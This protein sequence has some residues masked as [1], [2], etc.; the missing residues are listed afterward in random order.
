MGIKTSEFLKNNQGSII[1]KYKKRYL[2]VQKHIEGYTPQMHK[3]PKWLMDELAQL[4]GKMHIALSTYRIRRY[5]FKSNW[6]SKGIIDQKINKFEE[7]IVK[8]YE[9]ADNFTGQII[10]DL[11]YKLSLVD[12]LFTYEFNRKN[13]SFVNSHGDVAYQEMALYAFFLMQEYWAR[14]QIGLHYPE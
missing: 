5:E 14:I 6:L 10:D 7:L 2:S 13:I 4:L 8:A 3:S 12:R 11:K 1:Y 9:N